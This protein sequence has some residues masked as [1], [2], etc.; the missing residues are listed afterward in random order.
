MLKL[1]NPPPKVARNVEGSGIKN[2]RKSIGKISI[3]SARG[4]SKT[5]VTPA[6]KIGRER[7]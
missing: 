6:T 2:S 3:R 4:L 7:I 5:S 1:A